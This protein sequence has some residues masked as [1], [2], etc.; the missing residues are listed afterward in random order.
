M[1]KNTQYTNYVCI[2]DDNNYNNNNCDNVPVTGDEP[3]LLFDLSI[4][5]T[6]KMKTVTLHEEF[7]YTLTISNNGQTGVNNFS[8]RDYLPV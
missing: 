6:P 1:Q 5:K 3:A 2:S 8:V 7:D 4:D